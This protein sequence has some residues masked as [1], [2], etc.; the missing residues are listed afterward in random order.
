[1]TSAWS[2]TA[3]V[4]PPR[5]AVTDFPLGHTAGRPNQPDEQV[6]VIRDALSLFES[7]E[8]PGTI[9]PLDYD[10]GQEWK[11][12]AREL[13]DHRA[14]RYDTPQYQ[15]SDDRAAAIAGHGED[16]ACSI[17]EPGMVPRS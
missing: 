17:C 3:A 13:V 1:M 5:A 12:A 10:W 16:V 6:A 9:V 2:I 14:P 11:A 8:Q 4:N 15:T 7:I